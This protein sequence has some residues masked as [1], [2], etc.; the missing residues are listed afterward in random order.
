MI[1]SILLLPLFLSASVAAQSSATVVCVAGQCLEGFSNITI[2]TKLSASG[3]QTSL[4]LLPGQ[5]TSTTNPQLLHN[6][7]TSSSAS[8]SPSP[9]FN[10]SSASLPLNVAL[11]PGVAI[12]SE[13]LYSGQAGFSGLPTSPVGNSSSGTPLSAG[14]LALSSN[15]WAAISPGSSKDR[16]ILWDSVPDVSQLP[17]NAAG[18]LSLL[19]IESASCSPPCSGSGV[20]SASGTCTCPSGFTGSSCES[21]ASGFFGPT[22]Q[23]CPAGCSQCDDGI[24]GSGRC[25]SF[26]VVNPPS[27]CNCLNGQC[28]SN[29]QCTCNSGWTTADNGTACAKCASGFFLD[30]NGD[31]SICELGCTSCADG[32]GDCL[33]C[34]SGFTLDANDRTKCI[35]QQSVTSTG[36]TCPDGSFSNGTA[37]T[38][39]STECQ[40]CTGASSNQCIICGSGRYMLNGTCVPADGNGVCEGSSLIANNDKHE[41]DSCPSKCTSCQIP[42]FSVASTVNQLQCAG[43]L[44]GFVLS[45]GQCVQS[46][47]SGTF[48]SPTDN[49]TCTA[50]DSSCSTCAGSSTFCLTCAN[51][52]LASSGKCVASCP[53][54]TFSSSGQCV[55]CH[56]DCATCSG[57]AFNQCSSCS[58]SRPVLTNG[59][60]LPTCSKSQYF[61][62]T[63]SS[64]QSCDS[65]CS[66][67]SGSGP[68]SCLA[69]SS[70]SQVLR[71]GTCASANC[72]GTSSVI[73]G[74]GVCLS[75]LVIVPQASGTSSATPLPSITGIDQ[76]TVV[77]NSSRPLQWWEILLMALGCAFIF[78]VFLMCWRRQMR[79]RRAKATAQFAVAKSLDRKETWRAR[80][81]QF[82]GRKPGRGPVA[83]QEDSEDIKLMKMRNAEE[84]RRDRD[85]EKL[86]GAY[87]YSRPSSRAPSEPEAQRHLRPD[88]WVQ[89]DRSSHRLSSNSLFSEMTGVPTRGPQ[90]RQPVKPQNLQSRFSDTTKG[91]SLSMYSGRSRELTPPLPTE[92]AVYARQKEESSLNGAGA[93]SYWVTPTNTGSSGN[94]NPFRR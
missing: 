19:D 22:C 87:D 84:A 67:C 69:C 20:C 13:S 59:R 37:C 27:S 18:S 57:S 46:C 53:S 3:L 49:L 42:S 30:S 1:P 21:C 4:L 44:P 36:T 91:D 8:L 41:C 70:S 29:G 39:C 76:P 28:G 11:E 48:L 58:S 55:L 93:G 81:L 83:L 31:C 33:S 90:P 73:P 12:Y 43:C 47:P 89:D 52:Q 85:F 38:P 61:D 45:K 5:Y 72:N 64:C 79:K 51:N 14:S 25:L 15:V 35:A 65:S 94:K 92:A 56:P 80:I 40:T 66:S 54:N 63:S 24:S 34:A 26:A 10:S 68:S 75:E 2:G 16:I 23:A 32:N 82:F 71:G 9:G 7:L 6:A 77:T 60:C 86:L 62:A 17:S 78:V 74:L 50:C 88:S